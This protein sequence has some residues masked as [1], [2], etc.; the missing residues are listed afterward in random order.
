MEALTENGSV[1]FAKGGEKNRKK[2]AKSQLK[3]IQVV[4]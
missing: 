4:E 1:S 2:E 3:S